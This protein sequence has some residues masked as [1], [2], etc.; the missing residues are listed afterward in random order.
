MNR[1]LSD[2]YDEIID[3]K[4]SLTN[5]STLLPSSSAYFPDLLAE[6]SSNSRV[7]IWRLIAY[8]VAFAIW[9]HE[10]VFELFKAQVEEIAAGAIPGT[11]RWYFDR[12]LEFQY[13]EPLVYDNGI[14]NYAGDN[15][16]L[17]IV[18]Y[19]AIEERPDGVVVVKTAKDS[20]GDPL[21]LASAELAALQSYLQQIKFAGTRLSVV[22]FAPDQLKVFYEIFYDPIVPLQD[23]QQEVELAIHSFVKNLPFNGRFN[24]NKLTDQLQLLEGVTDPVFQSA[25]ARYGALPYQAVTREYSSNAGSLEIDSSAPLSTTITYTPIQ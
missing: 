18:K 6:L 22:S 2:I 21:E 5:L 10:Q 1:S 7:A 13:G 4:Q 20:N 9:T 24:I 11:A 23:V 14:Y 17:Q 8:V 25:E 19:C 3:E 12:V 15:P 16:A